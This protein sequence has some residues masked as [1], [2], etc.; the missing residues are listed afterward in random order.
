M[1]RIF[2]K[3]IACCFFTLLLGGCALTGFSDRNASGYRQLERE[4]CVPYARR[5]SGIN[6]R[7]NANTWWGKAQNT[8]QR[9]RLP[10][11]GALLVLTQTQRLPSGHLAVVKQL[12]GPREIIVTHTN[13]GDDFM[14]RRIVY[15]AMRVQDVS[16]MNDWSS[17]RFWNR[18]VDAYGFPYPVQGFI[19]PARL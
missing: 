8:Y 9:G 10:A 18:E 17:V 14:S 16:P 19:Y 2:L 15:E 12:A 5:V 3:I 1:P 7:G 13:W 4:Q 6:L 11:P